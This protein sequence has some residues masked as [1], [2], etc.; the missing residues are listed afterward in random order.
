M[1]YCKSLKTKTGI[2]L[3]SIVMKLS[4][5]KI[6]KVILDYIS[7]HHPK[8]DV[9]IKHWW[10]V[11]RPLQWKKPRYLNDKINWLKFHADMSVWARMAD[12]FAVRGYVKERGCEEILNTLYGKYDSVEELMDDWSNLPNSFVIKSN[13][14]VGSLALVKDKN[15]QSIEEIRQM[16][17]DMLS[18][19]TWNSAEPHYS[20]I[21]N[22]I[23]VEELLTDESIKEFSCSLIDYKIWCFN[24][25]PYCIFVAYDRILNTSHHYFKC[26]DLDWNEHKE[27]MTCDSPK[28]QINRPKNLNKMLEYAS[29]LS[30]GNPQCRVDLY[31]IDG[32]IYFGELTM[33][34]QGGFMDYFTKEYLFAMGKQIIL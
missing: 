24:G 33:T 11:G 27:Y 31:N 8:L 32:K 17:Q 3:T 4:S 29:R 28:V 22:C 5:I 7:K 9:Y 1:V 13:N 15:N 21:K 14:G 2:K 25:K 16:A 26:F 20:L 6:F 10:I 23:I 30:T 19:T 12:K 18:C 34:S